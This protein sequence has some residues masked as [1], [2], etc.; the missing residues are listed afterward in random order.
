MK[1]DK[2]ILG[3][4]QFGLEYGINNSRGKPKTEE[5]FQILKQAKQAGITTLDTADAYGNATQLVGNFNKE[6]N[7][8]FLINTK[9]KIDFEKE[10]VAEQL[11][12]SLELL[13]TNSV[14]V[15]FYHSFQ[16]LLDFPEVLS[17]LLLLRNKGKIKKIGVSVYTNEEFDTVINQKEIDVI[18]IPFNVLDNIAQR[19]ELICKAKLNKKTIQVRSVFL[20]GLFF[21]D[22]NSYP[23]KLYPLKRYVSA[24]LLIVKNSGRTVED[25]CLSYALN[26][27]DIDQVII[28]VDSKEQ[29]EQNLMFARSSLSEKIKNEIDA[30][31]VN[32]VELLHP[33]NWN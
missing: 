24:F 21:K 13:Q 12:R 9:F 29:L 33:K 20:Q 28:G 1:P 31:Q 5:V 19:G 26:Q 7:T 16:Q 10:G 14:E 4:V 6:Y 30:I 17:Q 15:Y 18:Q 22:I 2:L 25:I 27:P 3:T 11:H 8:P 32:E 23:D